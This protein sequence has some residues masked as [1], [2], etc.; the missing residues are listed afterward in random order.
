MDG[1]NKFIAKAWGYSSDDSG[2]SVLTPVIPVLMP[3]GTSFHPRYGAKFY[4]AWFKGI[5]DSDILI[6]EFDVTRYVSSI[7]VYSDYALHPI[8]NASWNNGLLGC[9][10]LGIYTI[11]SYSGGTITSTTRLGG[12]SLEVPWN[13]SNVGTLAIGRF[14]RRIMFLREPLNPCFNIDR[15]ESIII[16]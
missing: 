16:A 6:I 9:G 1:L 7:S 3:V 5:G 15:L 11:D 13:V 2:E 8:P 10:Y 12:V 14:L 4:S